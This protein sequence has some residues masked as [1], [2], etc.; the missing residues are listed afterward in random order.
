MTLENKAELYEAA[1]QQL[2]DRLQ[3]E[4]L[5]G[6]DALEAFVEV[7]H[8]EAPAGLP[9]FWWCGVY[10]LSAAGSGGGGGDRELALAAASSPACSPIPVEPRSG[11]VCSDCVLIE[12][13]VVVPDVGRYPGHVVCDPRARSEIVV[14]L[15]RNGG[16]IAG[17]IDVDDIKTASFDNDDA[18]LIGRF[19][20]LLG[21]RL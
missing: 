3:R 6:G 18:A 11:G 19:A 15:F 13:P 12:K 4:G 20:E 21:S 8:R 2:E 9:H 14:P 5:R 17:V 1:F 10:L 7:T 16:E